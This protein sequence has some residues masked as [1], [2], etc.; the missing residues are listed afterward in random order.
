MLC[1]T[2]D[3]SIRRPQVQT[4]ATIYKSL[5]ALWAWNPQQVSKMTFGCL[6]AGSVQKVSAKVKRSVQKISKW[7]NSDQPHRPYL[8]KTCPQNMLYNGGLYGIEGPQ[9]QGILQRIW[10]ADPKIC[11]F[12]SYEP[13]LLGVEVV[14]NFLAKGVGDFGPKGL[15]TPVNCGSG[16]KPIANPAAYPAACLACSGQK[17]ELQ[18]NRTPAWPTGPNVEQ[19]THQYHLACSL[20]W[21]TIRADTVTK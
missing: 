10:H 13:S 7:N 1:K 11:S 20:P 3:G 15:D 14:F 6:P 17:S 5:R 12:L 18:L 9:N 2:F 21:S 8:P 16:L 19:M 4:R